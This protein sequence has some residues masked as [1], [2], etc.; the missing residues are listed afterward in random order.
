MGCCPWSGWCDKSPSPVDPSGSTVGD[1]QVYEQN[2]HNEQK[3][4]QRETWNSK[5]VK[6][7]RLFDKN[8]QEWPSS[9]NAAASIYGGSLKITSHK[10]HQRWFLELLV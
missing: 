6:S 10:K 2:Q 7:N 9:N 4:N 5:R 3:R 8:L 1:E